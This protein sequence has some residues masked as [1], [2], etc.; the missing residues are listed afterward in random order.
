MKTK[1][2]EISSTQVTPAIRSLFRRDEPQAPR[3]FRVLDGVSNA[4]RIITDDVESPRWS[5]VLE[6]HDGSLY[7]GGDIDAEIMF[8]VIT[9]L[10]QESDVLVGLWLGD[11]RLD[12][13]P[14]RYYY[15][16]CVLEFYDRSLGRGLSKYIEDLPEGCIL[17][18][19]DKNLIMHTE[20]GP[21]D[22]RAVGGAENWE[23]QFLGYCL[24]RN[25]KIVAEA[26]AGPPALG[27]Y[28]PGVFTQESHRQKGY[29]TM[30]SARLIQEIEALGGQTYWNCAKQN[31]GSAGIARHLG[32]RI[33][34]EYRCI[35]WKRIQ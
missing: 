17:Q 27:M 5:V 30:V 32:Y 9:R 35:A 31:I 20:W 22:V 16:G 8:S 2:L 4:G 29:G 11:P 1:M 26:T 25:D 15:D 19:L 3:C 34:K 28:E 6:P 21:G 7:F 12:L 10:R 13:L 24:I 23:R 18:R 33:V 14:P